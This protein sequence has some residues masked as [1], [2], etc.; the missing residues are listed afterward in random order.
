ML[1]KQTLVWVMRDD[2]YK[3]P[4]VCVIHTREVC[5]KLNEAT[6]RTNTEFPM[7]PMDYQEAEPFPEGSIPIHFPWKNMALFL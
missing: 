4:E 1:G 7:V 2:L 3:V 5:Q 6:R